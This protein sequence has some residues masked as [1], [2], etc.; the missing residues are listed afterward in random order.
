[1]LPPLAIEAA[2]GQVTMPPA[3]VPP[4]SAETKVTPCGRVSCTTTLEAVQIGR[5]SCREREEIELGAVTLAGPVLLTARSASS[6]TA[7]VTRFAGAEP[8][9]VGLS[10]LAL[11]RW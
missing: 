3:S 9:L 6:P 10:G 5:A 1:M 11:R 2:A 7:V 8:S 4:L